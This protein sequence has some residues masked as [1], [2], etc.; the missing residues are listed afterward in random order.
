MVLPNVGVHWQAAQTDLTMMAELGSKER[1][2]AQ[3]DA[4]VERAGLEIMAVH[5]YNSSLQNSI[6]VVGLK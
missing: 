3:W 6:M 1:T 5:T 2:R 4:L